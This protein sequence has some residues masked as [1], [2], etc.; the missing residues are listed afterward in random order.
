VDQTAQVLADLQVVI[1]IVAVHGAQV[2]GGT[3]IMNGVPVVAARRLRAMLRSLPA[4]LGPER[5]A[6]PADQARV[7][8]HAAALLDVEG[9]ILDGW[10]R[11]P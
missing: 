11:P 9:H 3:V 1:S 7:R 5:V 6:W 10:L 8:F 4:V 2:P